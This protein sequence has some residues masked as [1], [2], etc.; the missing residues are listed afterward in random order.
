MAVASG[1]SRLLPVLVTKKTLQADFLL[2]VTCFVFISER[3]R[4]KFKSL[5]KIKYV[6]V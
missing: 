2:V 1:A 6:A 3:D 4:V 5:T